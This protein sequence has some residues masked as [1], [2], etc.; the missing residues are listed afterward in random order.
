MIIIHF[1]K[2]HIFF[3]ITIQYVYSFPHSI[4]ENIYLCLFILCLGSLGIKSLK[5]VLQSH[6]SFQGILWETSEMEF[7]S[8]S[9][10]TSNYYKS[11]KHRNIPQEWRFAFEL[12]MDESPN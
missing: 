4:N 9:N 1:C 8:T 5:I 2:Q 12:I 6:G 7:L 10:V 3:K 11:T